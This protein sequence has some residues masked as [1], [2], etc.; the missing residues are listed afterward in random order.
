[1]FRRMMTVGVTV[2]VACSAACGTDAPED[3]ALPE[4]AV[5]LSALPNP[6]IQ[7]EYNEQITTD[8]TRKVTVTLYYDDDELY[9]EDV[10][11][12]DDATFCAIPDDSFTIGL[13]GVVG[14]TTQ[15]GWKSWG[16]GWLCQRPVFELSIPTNLVPSVATLS[17]RDDSV[18]LAYALGNVLGVRTLTSVDHPDWAFA[19]G[20]TAAFTWSPASDLDRLHTVTVLGFTDTALDSRVTVDTIDVSFAESG[21]GRLRFVTSG[22]EDCGAGCSLHAYQFIEHEATVAN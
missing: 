10:A 8:N 7:I 6:R 3:R 4:R 15:A 12:R 1:M 22:Q 16:D 21:S 17:M 13:E 9:T 20:E 5:M 11:P 19:R 18:E 2:G 14:K